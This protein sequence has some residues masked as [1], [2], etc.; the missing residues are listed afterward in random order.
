MEIPAVAAAVLAA[1]APAAAWLD[2]T[3]A[4]FPDSSIATSCAFCTAL[5]A[6][7][8]A[9]SS[10]SIFVFAFSLK[11]HIRSSYPADNAY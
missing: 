2:A 11:R 10:Y 4:A 6:F 1:M 8:F 7:R 9:P 3:I 5:F